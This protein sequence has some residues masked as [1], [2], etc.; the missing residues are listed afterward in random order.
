[1]ENT[2]LAALVGESPELI[3]QADAKRAQAWPRITAIT[4]LPMT[5]IGSTRKALLGKVDPELQRIKV[6]IARI[7]S[8]AWW[9]RVDVSDD[10]RIRWGVINACRHGMPNGS[11]LPSDFYSP[12][13]VALRTAE[14]Q[15]AAATAAFLD[16]PKLKGSEKQ[17]AWAETIRA[18]FRSYCEGCMYDDRFMDVAQSKAAQHAKFWIENRTDLD[19]RDMLESD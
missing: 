9:A 1:M 10:E 15:K 11:M 3:A 4:D 18:K 2:Q 16:L 7:N 14:S 13:Q 5:Q 6:R 19:F 8:A 17:V 12:Q